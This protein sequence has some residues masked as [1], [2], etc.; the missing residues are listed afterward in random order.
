MLFTLAALLLLPIAVTGDAGPFGFAIVFPALVVFLGL[1]PAVAAGGLRL[2]RWRSDRRWSGRLFVAS[3]VVLAVAVA[4]I[5]LGDR[6][7]RRL[8]ERTAEQVVARID[9]LAG[10]CAREAVAAVPDEVETNP[11]VAIRP[12]LTSAFQTCLDA[13]SAEP[14]SCVP[15]GCFTTLVRLPDAPRPTVLVDVRTYLDRELQG[16]VGQPYDRSDATAV[17]TY[18]PAGTSLAARG[19]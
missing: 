17:R 14:L 15:S 1:F 3:I 8:D 9:A 4:G 10:A 16:R 13:R 5:P 18:D 19:G 11:G 12:R 2:R 6:V 7:R